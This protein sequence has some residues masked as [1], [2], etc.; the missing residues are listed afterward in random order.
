MKLLAFL[1]R[2]DH[3]SYRL[4]SRAMIRH[5]LGRHHGGVAAALGQI[6]AR[7]AILSIGC[8]RPFPAALAV[9]MAG[10]IRSPGRVQTIHLRHGH[11]GFLSEEGLIGSWLL[12]LLDSSE[13]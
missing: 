2:F 1:E 5:D 13:P 12:Q 4:L 10:K 3:H 11:D 6:G 9:E 7:T 8:D